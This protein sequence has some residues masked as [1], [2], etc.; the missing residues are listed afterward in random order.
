MSSEATR[1]LIDHGNGDT[2]A[3]DRLL[4]LVYDELR[5]IA[6]GYLR[7]ERDGHTLQP[8]A[9]VHEA[10]VRLIDQRVRWQSRAH[11][12]GVAAQLMRRI[13][14]DYARGRHADKRGGG[15]AMVALDEAML[16]PYEKD[17]DVVA[18]DD[19][20]QALS[21]LDPQQSRVVELRFFGGLSIEEAAEVLGVS[22][23][24]VSRDWTV[25]R[26]WLRRE[27]AKGDSE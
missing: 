3:L 13:L 25:A 20:L 1:L 12:L 27:I 2:A 22:S 5:K 4:P 19:A 11:F 23:S 14:V 6:A 24:T 26:T 17:V 15:F 18:L 16:A 21:A 10:Y 7:R 8:T 9:L